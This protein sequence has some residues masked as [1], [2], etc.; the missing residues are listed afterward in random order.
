MKFVLLASS[1][2]KIKIYYRKLNLTQKNLL[3]KCIVLQNSQQNKDFSDESKYVYLF[4]HTKLMY[5]N[6]FMPSMIK[7]WYFYL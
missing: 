7:K 4:L 5:P 6:N 3:T 2:Y 1:H